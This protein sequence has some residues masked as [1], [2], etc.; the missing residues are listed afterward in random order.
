MKT[1]LIGLIACATMTCQSLEELKQ[2]YGVSVAQT[3]LARPEISVTATYAA[4][5]RI[6]QLR[7]SPWTPEYLLVGE[8]TISKDSAKAI[9]DELLPGS[10][11][12]KF[13]ISEFIDLICLPRNDCF[14]VSED[15]E[16][17]SIYY[18][19]SETADRVHYAVV[20]WK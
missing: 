5:G 10:K 13:V 14:G 17:V 6:V 1:L 2:K 12:G 15:Y 20:T 9:I 8:K 11:R 19:S 18:N 3:F 16:K 7:I 4:S